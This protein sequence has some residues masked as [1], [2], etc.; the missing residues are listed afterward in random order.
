MYTDYTLQQQQM[1]GLPF[2]QGPQDPALLQ[3]YI[4]SQNLQT[5]DPNLQ[6][7]NVAMPQQQMTQPQPQPQQP[8]A[9][10]G[11]Q[12]AGP[13][14]PGALPT[15]APAPAPQL[16]PQ[17]QDQPQVQA[18][19]QQQPAPVE[20]AQPQP[21]PPHAVTY[22]DIQQ[23]PTAL[24]NYAKNPDVPEHMK[25][26]ATVRAGDLLSQNRQKDEAVQKVATMQPTELANALKERTTGG[27]WTKAIIYGLLGMHNMAQ[28]E[29]AKLGI[30]KD[31]AIVGPDGKPY[32]IKMAAN[33]TPL[34]GFDAT[35]GAKLK[36][37][38]LVAAASGT[39][40]LKGANAGGQLYRDE[41]G[42]SLTK[43]DSLHGPIWYNAAGQ[44]TIPAG[45]PV[46]LTAGTDLLT[47][48]KLSE[49]KRK[50][51]FLGQTANQRLQSF[52]EY[53]NERVMS[54]QQPYTLDQMGLTP[55]GEVLGQTHALPTNAPSAPAGPVTPSP[56]ITQPRQQVAPAVPGSPLPP[57]L[58]M[59]VPAGA[60]AI[61]NV[62]GTNNPT[63][64]T[65]AQMAAQ[66]AALK[67]G[68][69]TLASETA[70]TV[71]NAAVAENTINDIDH[72]LGILDTGKHN[73]GPMLSGAPLSQAVGTQLNTESARNTK[74]VM[75]TVRAIGGAMSQGA[76]KGHLTN[77]ELQFLTEN[78]PTERSDPEYTKYWLNKAKKALENIQKQ[79]QS[80]VNLGGT[81]TNPV[82][83]KAQPGTK[84][85][86]IKLD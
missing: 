44:R 67:K 21:V 65:G 22:A 81:A 49:M 77:Q 76:I 18:Q 58:P 68:E 53:N 11:V 60:P 66:R 6:N 8:Q 14:V 57:G 75:D 4:N 64:M 33:G 83:N 10:P 56:N 73:I 79:A 30:G 17:S 63:Q 74:E 55:T 16:Q 46:P 13:M 72:A 84:E 51:Q 85:N 52:K 71:A 36:P 41:K 70:K 37:H 39:D 69:S 35:T 61:T 19:S 20:Q 62:P 26:Q 86:P 82:V 1:N 31:T 40:Y 54:G 78:K 45:Q 42:N 32:L 43:I 25:T 7:K 12:L 47:Q 29:A 5:Q 48:T 50:E 59:G 27:S 34:E 80:Q 9:Q 28:D 38:E 24:L 3:D 2:T 15:Q 23:D